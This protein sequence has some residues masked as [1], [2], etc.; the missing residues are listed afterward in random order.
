MREGRLGRARAVA[1]LAIAIAVPWG[2]GQA[3]LLE[4][5]LPTMRALADPGDGAFA[6]VLAL[7]AGSALLFGPGLLA[8]TTSRTRGTA[9]AAT[10]GAALVTALATPWGAI[11]LFSGVVTGV[12]TETVL[13]T[14]TRSAP[15][16]E[17]RVI[18]SGAVLGLL[19]ALGSIAGHGST[20]L[21]VAPLLFV[22]LAS[23][24]AAAA[25][26]FAAHRAGRLL[27]RAT[28]LRPNGDDRPLR[29]DS[30]AA[31]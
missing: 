27:A 5:A 21:S 26:A 10:L 20:G 17:S 1:L 3:W 19:A 2:L 16:S 29:P 24:A 7:N 11:A 18:A 6:S 22:L 14:L 13:L 25:L 30:P 8:W 15:G 4:A 31:S 23:A 9:F 12:L 28:G